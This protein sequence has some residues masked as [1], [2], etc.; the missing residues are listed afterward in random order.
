M[1]RVK[2][3]SEEPCVTLPDTRDEICIKMDLR[4]DG[5]CEALG[6]GY[7]VLRRWKELGDMLMRRPGWYF[8]LASSERHF[9]PL[10][11]FGLEG[12][13]R[14]TITAQMEGF[15]AFD[16]EEGAS[17]VIPRR[18]ALLDWL[19]E[20]EDKYEGLTP[21]AVLVRAELRRLSEARL[22]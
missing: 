7:P 20:R 16:Y 18:A 17:Q 12:E 9:G 3:N 8:R 10:W 21:R 14:L 1:R 11:C 4:Y 13:A 5:L 15:L 2:P 19:H 22:T 6:G